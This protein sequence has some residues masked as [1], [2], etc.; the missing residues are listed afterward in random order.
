MKSPVPNLQS[1][2]GGQ[3]RNNKPGREGQREKGSADWYKDAPDEKRDSWRGQ[4][5]S[6]NEEQE[7]YGEETA[8]GEGTAND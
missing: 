8:G 7:R 1:T 4:R 2:S 6:L 3:R 5:E